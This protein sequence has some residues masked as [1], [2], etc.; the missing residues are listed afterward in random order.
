MNKSARIWI[1]NKYFLKKINFKE[2]RGGGGEARVGKGDGSRP[3]ARKGC[4][5]SL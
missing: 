4:T 2:K 5:G 1:N 3:H